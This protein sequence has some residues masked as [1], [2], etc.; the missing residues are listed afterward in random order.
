MFII[1]RG[2][3]AGDGERASCSVAHGVRRGG[4]FCTWPTPSPPGVSAIAL[5]PGGM[6]SI[7]SASP[8]RTNDMDRKVVKNK[9]LA[10]MKALADL[11]APANPAGSGGSREFALRQV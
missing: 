6:V 10:E 9:R 7:I 4:I 3:G 11:E 8:L 2:R 1:A 5:I